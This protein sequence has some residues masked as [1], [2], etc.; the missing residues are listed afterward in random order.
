VPQQSRRHR[1]PAIAGPIL[2]LALALA[3]LV[4]APAVLAQD[5]TDGSPAPTDIGFEIEPPGEPSAFCSVLTP[6]EATA[7]LGVTLTVGT[8]SETDCSWD[9]DFVTSDISLIGSRDVGDLESDAQGVFPDGESL[10]VD[11][12][13]AWYAPVDY[14][15]SVDVGDG[16]L[17]TLALFGT[18]PE[19]VD[20]RAALTGLASLALPRL[21]EVPV[22]VDPTEAPEP[23]LQGD[24]DLRALIPTMVGDAPMDVVVYSGADILAGADMTDPAAEEMV[25]GLEA[26]LTGH[27]K[28]FD[29]LSIAEGYFDGGDAFGDLIATRIAGVD[30]TQVQDELIAYWLPFEDPRRTPGTVAGREV[31]IVSHGPLAAGSPDPSADPFD[32]ESA[33]SYVYPSGDV[34]FIISADE[35]GLTQLFEL[36]P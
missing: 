15:L 31:T 2:C 32:I 7:A 22:T 36:L 8:S 27:G 4:W 23:T 1:G 3:G 30:I 13:A 5:P 11:G 29:D 25:G 19:D 33:P 6:E 17:F 21:A 9:S 34:L 14:I 20:V 26:I 35:P 12:R 16:M 28:D 10:D 24:A 18:P